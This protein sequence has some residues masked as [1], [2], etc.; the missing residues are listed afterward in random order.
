MKLLDKKF[1]LA[2]ILIT[3]FIGYSII[4]TFHLS[5]IIPGAEGVKVWNYG[6]QF[7][8]TGNIL[9]ASE[10]D[11]LPQYFR[12]VDNSP[13]SMIIEHVKE[14]N[15]D[16]LLLYQRDLDELYYPRDRGQLHSEVQSHALF[17]DDPIKAPFET[18]EYFKYE[19]VSETE[20]RIVKYVVRLVPVD[21]IIQID[22]PPGSGWYHFKDVSIWYQMSSYTW[23]NAYMK[24]P[25]PDPNPLINSS[26]KYLS[27]NYRGAFPICVWIQ[28]YEDYLTFR[29]D[30]TTKT[31][32][33]DSE[34]IKYAVLRPDKAGRYIDLYT[35]PNSKY[36]LF[37]NQILSDPEYAKKALEPS[38]LPSPEFARD[39]WFKITVVEMGAYVK[40]LRYGIL[41][42]IADR[43][44]WYPSV[45]YRIRA[46][47]AV[48]GEYVYLWT[49]Q[50]AQTY[51]Y[52]Q[53]ETRTPV[54]IEEERGGL[55][56]GILKW[57]ENPF[58]V[59]GLG[60]FILFSIAVVT[61]ILI[62]WFF[63]LPKRRGEA[64]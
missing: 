54:I 40:P 10:L 58:N 63:G 39:V 28:G 11:P 55:F 16:P 17:Y 6:I 37:T 13:S 12:W 23:A 57:F 24:S 51:S 30:L 18:I 25:P 2:I 43:E 34:A 42:D 20:V 26:V 5:T 27:S 46:L 61:V 62:W 9:R 41:G 56:T 36:Y 33:V 47:Y 1:Y 19:K 8:A 64:I 45:C 59:I 35:S 4:Y 14:F 60:V 48:Y 3:I 44:I 7:G 38:A 21:F 22:I 49:T 50:K 32:T 53:W 29:K 15:Y 52:P 31:T